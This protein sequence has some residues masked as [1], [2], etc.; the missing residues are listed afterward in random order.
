MRHAAVLFGL[1]VTMLVTGLVLD[2]VARKSPASGI[3]LVWNSD[4]GKMLASL[5]ARQARIVN[6]WLSGHVVQL[7]VES[8]REFGPSLAATRL[9]IR[10][11]EASVTLA[12]CG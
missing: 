7:H 12:G 9:T 5:P 6:T 11:P 3:V 4:P 10:L 8:M 1:V 2:G